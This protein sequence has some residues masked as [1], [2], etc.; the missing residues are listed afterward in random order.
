[1]SDVETDGEE[2]PK[3]PEVAKKLTPEDLEYKARVEEGKGR[4][5]AATALREEAA[6]LRKG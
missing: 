6:K 4:I 3:A 1:M 5:F 2:L